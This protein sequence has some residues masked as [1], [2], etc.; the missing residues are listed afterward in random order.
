MAHVDAKRKRGDD[1]DEGWEDRWEEE[2]PLSS[3]S[4]RASTLKRSGFPQVTIRS[5]PVLDAMEREQDL[6]ERRQRRCFAVEK[7]F[8]RI[9]RAG[10]KGPPEDGWS[11]EL[12]TGLRTDWL[13]QDDEAMDVLEVPGQGRGYVAAK[14][15]KAGTTLL[16]SRP[17]VAYFEGAGSD[18]EGEDEDDESSGD[19]H[20][21][22]ESGAS[23]GS[24]NGSRKDE[25]SSDES[26]RSEAGSIESWEE[27][28]SEG[29]YDPFLVDD[30][31]ASLV[32]QLVEALLDPERD[33]CTDSVIADLYPRSVR[34]NAAPF[35]KIIALL[36]LTLTRARFLKG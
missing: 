11:L 25:L 17:I 24:D 29:E 6:R 1:A 18:D 12:P 28:N 20:E 19:E 14:N 21:G 36:R 26:N 10:R 31:V 33:T 7:L 16:V 9:D 4:L 32:V 5:D 30:A 2:E 34:L 35:F 27:S 23:N 8:S 13:V 15:L 3:A 22:D